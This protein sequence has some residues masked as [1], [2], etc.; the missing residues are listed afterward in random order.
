MSRKQRTDTV[1]GAIEAFKDATQVIEPP[2][3]ITIPEGSMPHWYDI[4]ETRP[5]SAWTKPDL[6]AAANL[7]RTKGDIERISAELVIEGDTL[8]N[9]RGTL[10]VNPKHSLLENLSRREIALSRFLHIHAEATSG[11]STS[12]RKKSEAHKKAKQSIDSAGDLIAR[13]H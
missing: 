11:E 6:T 1:K 2:S 8:K 5:A 12:Q 3:H 4:I 7:A 13:P 9:D 10:I